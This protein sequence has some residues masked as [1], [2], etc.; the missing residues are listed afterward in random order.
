MIYRLTLAHVEWS[1]S[2]LLDNCKHIITSLSLLVGTT[3]K[4]DAL[5]CL[6]CCFTS[7]V[8]S[9]GHGGTVISPNH[10]FFLG[11]IEQAVDQN[12]VHTLSLVTDNNPS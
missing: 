9:Y 10:T 6:Y 12:F 11:K 3:V 8:N 4:H 7:T 1:C 5:I 2:I